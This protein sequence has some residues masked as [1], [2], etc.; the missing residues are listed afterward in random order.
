MATHIT[1][2]M[3][4]SPLDEVTFGK[5]SGRWGKMIV[6]QGAKVS[7]ASYTKTVNPFGET[8]SLGHK[9][10][11]L[12]SIGN[13]NL[14]VVGQYETLERHLTDKKTGTYVSLKPRPDSPYQLIVSTSKNVQD[15]V[16]KTGRC[17]RVINHTT[18]NEKGIRA[19]ILMHEA[20]HPGW[21]IGC[22][23]PFPHGNKSVSHNFAPSRSA[24][25]EIYQ[26]IKLHGTAN[27]FVMD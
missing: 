4:R 19:G 7:A 9:M 8:I 13:D 22:I 15:T 6:V 25:N 16:N 20:S 26:L 18:K 10:L 5:K 23:A 1:V 2:I 3:T 21:L 14:K 27:F 24:M 11:S 17:L 12:E